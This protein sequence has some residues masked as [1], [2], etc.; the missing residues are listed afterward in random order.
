MKWDERLAMKLLHV[1]HILKDS[2]LL[3]WINE[4]P[5]TYSTP[6]LWS[7]DKLAL[8]DYTSVTERIDAQNTKWNDLY[9]RWSS[10]TSEMVSYKEFIWALQCI[11][12]R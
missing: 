7:K 10:E 9:E 4:L 8:L 6:L 1:K 2:R 3:L 12:S 11:N 5:T